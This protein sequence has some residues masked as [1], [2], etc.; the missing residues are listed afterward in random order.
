[1]KCLQLPKKEARNPQ[2]VFSIDSASPSS[3]FFHLFICAIVHEAK[4]VF[5]PKDIKLMA[6]STGKASATDRVKGAGTAGRTA[7]AIL[8]RLIGIIDFRYALPINVSDKRRKFAASVD[9]TVGKET[10]EIKG[11]TAA[12]ACTAAE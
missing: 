11:S 6:M 9:L 3:S 10:D 1:M 8:T 12:V 2:D 7:Q 4:R 5:I